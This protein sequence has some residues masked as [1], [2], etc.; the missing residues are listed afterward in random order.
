[1][2]VIDLQSRLNSKE[3]P[4]A[5]CIRRD[6]FGREMFLFGLEYRMDG[7]LWSL[8]VLAY[9]REDAEAR[10]AAMRESL[11]VV[12]QVYAMIPA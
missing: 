6:D 12:G 10:V 4:D 3:G 1:M 7:S 9:S 8:T 5:D 11:A 2:E